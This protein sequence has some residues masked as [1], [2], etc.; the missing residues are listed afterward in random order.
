M[1]DIS[2]AG[3]AGL[4]AE[5]LVLVPRSSSSGLVVCLSLR[6]TGGG[7]ISSES[8]S[9]TSVSWVDTED[10]VIMEITEDDLLDP[11]KLDEDCL[12]IEGV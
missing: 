1:K 8:G 4:M 11:W 6:G 3:V 12:F 7:S 2:V 9:A 5:S 10:G